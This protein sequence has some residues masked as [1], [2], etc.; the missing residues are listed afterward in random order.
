MVAFCSLMLPFFRVFAF[1]AFRRCRL[2]STC[3]IQ[4]RCMIYYHYIVFVFFTFVYELFRHVYI[5]IYFMCM[6]FSTFE[7]SSGFLCVALY[8][9]RI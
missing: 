6:E 7:L 9:F 3:F 4:K 8:T 5:H 2:P 1:G